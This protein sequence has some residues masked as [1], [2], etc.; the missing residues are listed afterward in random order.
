MN[1]YDEQE[2]KILLDASV[3]REELMIKKLYTRH[4]IESIKEEYDNEIGRLNGS[5]G[6]TANALEN[7]KNTFHIGEFLIGLVVAFFLSMII[8]LLLHNK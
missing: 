7:E 5:L 2:Q 8:L 1:P 3:L 4:D 6:D